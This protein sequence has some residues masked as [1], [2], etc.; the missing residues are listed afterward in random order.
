MITLKR[1]SQTDTETAGALIENGFP[2]FVTLEP[3]WKE[4]QSDLSCIPKG[5]Y[6][7]KRIISAKFGETFE[8][9]GVPGRSSILFH[10]GNSHKDTHGCILIGKWF[11]KVGGQNGV[12]NSRIAFKEFLDHL[13]GIN[14]FELLVTG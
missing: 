4:N 1:I 9:T 7:C 10:G 5:N 3:P 13:R 8:I 14:E 12:L 2:I 11:E 6:R